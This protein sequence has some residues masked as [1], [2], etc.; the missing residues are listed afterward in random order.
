MDMAENPILGILRGLYLV[1]ADF[2]EII[3]DFAEICYPL[4]MSSE[5]IGLSPIIISAVETKGEPLLKESPCH[6]PR[7][8]GT[9]TYDQF[10]FKTHLH[11]DNRDLQVDSLWAH[12]CKDCGTLVVFHPD[13]ARELEKRISDI[14]G[15]PPVSAPVIPYR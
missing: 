2:I 8:S 15:T 3:C 7:C 11:G 6:T 14:R 4:N 1:G 10:Q 12:G 5:K 13:V 9:I